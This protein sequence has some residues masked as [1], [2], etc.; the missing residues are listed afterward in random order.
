MFTRKTTAIFGGFGPDL[1][2]IWCTSD[3]FQ[4]TCGRKHAR[5]RPEKMNYLIS[6][7]VVDSAGE[8]TETHLQMF[9]RK[10]TA[11]FGGFGPDLTRIWCG[12]NRFQ[13]TYARKH[14]QGVLKKN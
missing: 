4:M 8:D 3:R 11:I 14:G 5:K 10:T 9:T 12:S 7:L 6:S 1:T 13:M 2:R